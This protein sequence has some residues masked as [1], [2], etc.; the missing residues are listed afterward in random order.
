MFKQI[1]FWQSRICSPFVSRS[2]AYIY[3]WD[4]I[5]IDACMCGEHHCTTNQMCVWR[6]KAA[7][8]F[9]RYTTRCVVIIILISFRCVC[10]CAAKYNITKPLRYEFRVAIAAAVIAVI[11]QSSQIYDRMQQQQQNHHHQ[12]IHKTRRGQARLCCGRYP[13]G[14]QASIDIIVSTQHTTKKTLQE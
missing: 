13:S 4:N 14:H 10:R 9:K 5:D 7:Q 6:A 11:A 1:Y 2:T 12:S 3:R 8:R